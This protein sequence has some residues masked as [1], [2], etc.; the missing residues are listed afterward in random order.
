MFKRLLKE[1]LS[2][3]EIMKCRKC[4][5]EMPVIGKWGAEIPAEFYNLILCCE[6]QKKE[7]KL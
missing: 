1:I 3:K 7:K 2:G 5:K 4:G 6:C